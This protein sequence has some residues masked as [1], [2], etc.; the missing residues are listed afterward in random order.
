M[1]AGA[2]AAMV[3]GGLWIG[4][5]RTRVRMLG[6]VPLC[7]G[8]LWAAA[9][10]GPDLLVTGDGRH[11][12]LRM[13]DGS[14]ALLRDRAGNFTRQV[15]GENGGVEADALA[16]LTDRPDARCS[17]DLCVAALARR[18]RHWRVAATRSAYPVA[19]RDLV[20][21]CAASDVMISERRLPRACHPRWLRLD[22][23]TLARTGGIAVTFPDGSVRRVRGRGRHPWLDPPMVQP[24]FSAA[25][26]DRR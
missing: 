18:G 7:L 13:A 23:E 3:A 11:A 12:A 16:A 10:P 6:L 14:F 21:V 19:W 8:A 25:K 1:P 24:P 17:P 26:G 9:T 22:R 5:W 20:A 15:L 2:F 4:L